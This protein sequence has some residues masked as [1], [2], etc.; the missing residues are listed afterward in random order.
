MVEDECHLKGGDIC[1]RGWANRKQRL[2]VKVKNYSD[3]K[4]YYGALDCQSGEMFLQ[5]YSTANTTSTI[6]F[7]R[8]LLAQDPNSKILVI[9]DGASHHRSEEFRAFLT[10]INQEDDWKV[11]CL[12]FAPQRVRATLV[13]RPTSKP[14]RGFAIAPRCR[15]RASSMLPESSIL[16][17][18]EFVGCDVSKFCESGMPPGISAG[19]T[20]AGRCFAASRRRTAPEGSC[21][22]VQALS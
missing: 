11:H 21:P 17:R 14:L 13:E 22:F 9:W 19:E 8:E 10:Q 6:K 18:T 5:S 15:Q 20:H 2:D 1:G 3:S 4:T 12:R 16:G 7:I